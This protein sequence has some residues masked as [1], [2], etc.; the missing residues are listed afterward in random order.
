[1]DWRTQA[2][3]KRREGEPSDVCAWERDCIAIR[4]HE[5]CYAERMQQDK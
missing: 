5:A 3:A 2:G 1:M 4:L